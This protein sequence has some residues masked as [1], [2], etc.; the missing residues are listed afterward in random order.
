[1]GWA[2]F[3]ADFVREQDGDYAA[4]V[5]ALLD[6]GASLR[7]SEHAPRDA[8]VRALLREQGLA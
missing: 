1:M 6:A 8:L 2:C 5:H 7:A 4:C 3:G